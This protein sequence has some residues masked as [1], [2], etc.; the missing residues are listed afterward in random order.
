MHFVVETI[1]VARKFIIIIIIIIT[2]VGRIARHQ[3]LNDI[4]A[5]ALTT[6]FRHTDHQRTWWSILFRWKAIWWSIVCAMNAR[7][8]KPLTWDV[9]V[10]CT[11]TAS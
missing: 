2:F 4:I 9:N 6:S 1:S 10:I 8:T 11:F 7:E 3:G 5:W